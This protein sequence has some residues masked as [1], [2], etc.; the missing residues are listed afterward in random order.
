MSPCSMI[1]ITYLQI[2]CIGSTS[3][4]SCRITGISSFHRSLPFQKGY[5]FIAPTMYDTDIRTLETNSHEKGERKPV[6]GSALTQIKEE[7]EY[8]KK[9]RT[10]LQEVRQ[11]MFTVE[12]GVTHSPSTRERKPPMIESSDINESDPCM[13]ELCSKYHQILD[14]IKA[15]DAE[16]CAILQE[17]KELATKLEAT[18]EAGAAALRNASQKLYKHYQKQMDELK[19]RH[20]QEKQRLQA[21]AEEQEKNLEKS[22]E[23][24]NNLELKLQQK[25]NRA[26]ELERRIERMEKEKKEL[27]KRKQFVEKEMECKKYTSMDVPDSARGFQKLQLE[28]STL[29][30]K[31][32]HLNNV[33]TQQHR[34]LHSAINTIENLKMELEKQDKIVLRLKEQVGI[35]EAE[36]NRLKYKAEVYSEKQK[37][38]NSPASSARPLPKITYESSRNK[39]PYQ[40]LMNW[41]KT[42]A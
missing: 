29:Q 35:L 23:N 10:T 28:S 2:I 13:A 18:Q 34:N 1:W 22:L 9:M 30:E 15:K 42:S 37:E 20:E 36:N 38:S 33:V 27:M 5:I 31:I 11:Q 7:T 41:K 14:Q 17:N 26:I 6:Y 21:F 8:I 32:F 12:D 39:T 16:L 4:S 40:M 25:Q 19:Q 3:F 24:F